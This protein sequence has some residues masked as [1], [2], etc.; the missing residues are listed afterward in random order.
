MRRLKTEIENFLIETDDG[1]P[2][3]HV[4]Y[5]AD[6][7]TPELIEQA[8]KAAGRP[9]SECAVFNTEDLIKLEEMA[10]REKFIRGPEARLVIPTGPGAADQLALIGVGPGRLP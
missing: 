10:I 7:P 6:F 5:S 3:V 9:I 2:I 1:R 4:N 8:E